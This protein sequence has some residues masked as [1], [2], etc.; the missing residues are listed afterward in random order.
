M[1]RHT[2]ADNLAFCRRRARAGA[3][4]ISALLL[5]G[6]FLAAA[7]CASTRPVG[8][9]ERVKTRPRLEMSA[10]ELYPGSVTDQL[11]FFDELESRA[12]VSYDDALH[13]VLLARGGSA[14]TFVQ[15]AA[16]AKQAGIVGVNWSPQPRDAITVG[17][18]APMI[19][20]QPREPGRALSGLKSRGVVPETW[21]AARGVSGP[22]LLAILRTLA[23]DARSSAG[24][25]QP[26]PDAPRGANHDR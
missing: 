7:G 16:I 8:E 25:A 24:A 3:R 12:L 11:D 17:E 10:A 1:T 5:A 4:A 14:P 23:A 20:H 15:R 26:E 19:W 13:A 21:S 9:P 2:G 6:V 18:L 22:E